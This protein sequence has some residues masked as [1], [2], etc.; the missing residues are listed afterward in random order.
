MNEWLPKKGEKFNVVELSGHKLTQGAP[1]TCTGY[2]WNNS[3]RT[4]NVIQAT[5]TQPL[6]R[7]FY[8]FGEHAVTL[9]AVKDGK[10]QNRPI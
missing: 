4:I 5:D 9:E 2:V 8:L 10:V 1:F 3:G 7:I 6:P